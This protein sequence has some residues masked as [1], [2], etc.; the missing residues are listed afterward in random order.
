MIPEISVIV[1]FFNVEPYL[2]RCIDSIIGQVF[3]NIEIILVDDGSTDD[4]PNICDQYAITDARIKVI[5]KSHVGVSDARN[6]GLDI[7]QGKYVSFID[8]D[9]CIHPQMLSC[10]YEALTLNNADIAV[11]QPADKVH[12]KKSAYHVVQKKLLRWHKT[13]FEKA[14]TGLLGGSAWLF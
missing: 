3:S 13:S 8:S 9:D 11:C 1:P 2:A 12:L 7:A 14:Q 10:L 5:H 4:S 6:A